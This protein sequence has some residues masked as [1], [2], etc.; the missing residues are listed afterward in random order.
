M[1][2]PSDLLPLDHEGAGLILTPCPGIRGVEPRTA[3]EQ[4]KAAGA[5]ALITLMP[6]DEMTTN[7]VADIADLCSQ[8]GLQWFHL[9][10]EDEHAPEMDFALAWQAQRL[11]VHRLLDEGRKIALHCKGGSGRTGLMAA[12]VL[13]ERGWSKDRAV[14]TV[15]ALRPNALSLRVHQDYVAELAPA[16]PAG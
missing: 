6:A 4:L 1:T 9:P 2:H 15:K 7:G 16:A 3:L 8:S 5:D 10:I 13:V 11:A 12:L 14:T